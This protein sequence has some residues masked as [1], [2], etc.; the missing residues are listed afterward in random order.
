MEAE[1]L[2]KEHRLNEKLKKQLNEL[3]QMQMQEIQNMQQEFAQASELMD[4]K[5]KQLSD[6]FLEL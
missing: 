5:Y 3:V 4:Q 6:R 2:D 1:F